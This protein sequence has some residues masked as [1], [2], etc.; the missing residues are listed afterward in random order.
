[1]KRYNFLAI[2][3]MTIIFQFSNA[4]NSSLS[5]CSKILDE[6]LKTKIT[7][8]E[9]SELKEFLQ[10]YFTLEESERKELKKN[11][12]KDLGIE[13]IVKNIP[14]KIGGKSSKNKNSDFLNIL[15]KQYEQTGIISDENL[16][17]F[18]TEYYPIEAFESYNKCV[19]SYRNIKQL[20]NGISYNVIG[21]TNDV[22]TIIVS[23]RDRVGKNK[24]VIKA[25]NHTGCILIGSNNL[26]KGSK[27]KNNQTLQ[28]MF[29]RIP[30]SSAI[31]N[32]SFEETPG[33]EYFL[34]YEKKEIYKDN[35]KNT[36]IGT[37]VASVLPY[38]SF[39]EANGFPET[40][41]MS[42]AIWIPCDGR[43]E[44][45]SAY[46][47]FSKGKIPDLRGLFL[48]GI[49]DYG[50]PFD[51]VK[52]VSN[53]QKNPEQKIAGEFQLD[54]FKSHSHQFYGL[55]NPI[56]NIGPDG[57]N[58]R[59]YGTANTNAVGGLETRPKNITVYYYLK[60]N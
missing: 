24:Q 55:V 1:M 20:E 42:K 31:V 19:E 7:T 10:T 57:N 9:R 22:F 38:K 37:I 25:F 29:K 32:V 39:L 13:A 16:N 2:I 18:I 51:G 23:Y 53:E 11:S 58:Y 34:N 36:P 44:V 41:D 54:E 35:T 17:I 46:A 45:S 33:F 59:G 4:Q 43:T 21:D 12:S 8:Y 50:Y 14:I 3:I 48:R 27:I 30:N 5:E 26:R 15:K 6:S 60:I 49:N 28:Q 47:K 56:A 52:L 40:S